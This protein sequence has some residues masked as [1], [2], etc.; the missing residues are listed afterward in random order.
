MK[1][2]K[3]SKTEISLKLDL[4]EIFK[5]AGLKDRNID[6]D[7]LASFMQQILAAAAP[8][9]LTKYLESLEEGLVS[10]DPKAQ[11]AI[12]EIFRLKPSS[13]RAIN[14]LQQVGVAD[15]GSMVPA[16]R[17]GGVGLFDKIIR[18][19]E[20]ADVQ[21]SLPE[22]TGNKSE[23]EILDAEPVEPGSKIQ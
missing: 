17:T 2:R 13:G 1:R 15:S 5:K 18:E 9:L 10:G 23:P 21:K 11:V 14:I 7:G 4:P 6:P 3:L 12:A 22:P 19:I 8:A 20:K 16:H